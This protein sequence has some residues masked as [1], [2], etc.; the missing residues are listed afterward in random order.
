MRMTLAARI[1]TAT[2]GVAFATL[3]AGCVRRTLMVR[4][5][6][7]GARVFLNDYEV[8]TS[9]VSVDFTWYG[10]YDVIVRKDGYALGSIYLDPERLAGLLGYLDRRRGA[11]APPGGDLVEAGD[12]YWGRCRLRPTEYGAESAFAVLKALWVQPDGEQLTQILC[13]SQDL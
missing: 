6:P 2:C 12:P 3:P 9:P 8:G 4:T 13:A 11:R 5:E 7:E 10:D 1:L